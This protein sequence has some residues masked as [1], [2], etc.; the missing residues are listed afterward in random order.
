MAGDADADG[1]YRS[2]RQATVGPG[3]L[4]DQLSGDIGGGHLLPF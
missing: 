1:M 4:P 2:H 3:K